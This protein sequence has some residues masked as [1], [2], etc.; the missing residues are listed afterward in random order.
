MRQHTNG[1]DPHVVVVHTGQSQPNLPVVKEPASH[2]DAVKNTVAVIATGFGIVASCLTG[3]FYIVGEAKAES[4]KVAAD[5]GREVK[6]LRSDFEQYKL[7][8]AQERREDR[9]EIFELRNDVRGLYK[10]VKTG[11]DQPRL[12]KEVAPPPVD[13]GK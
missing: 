1:S 3:A 12:E 10:Y 9:A 5:A 13:G 7:D 11:R 8:R 6:T 2:A 4:A